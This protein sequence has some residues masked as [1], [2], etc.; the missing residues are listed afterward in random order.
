M[1]E[2]V[3]EEVKKKEGKKIITRSEVNREY[4][5]GK[6][7]VRIVRHIAHAE[8]AGPGEIGENK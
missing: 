6:P 1:N 5:K 3:E 4:T 2:T 7:K 8:C